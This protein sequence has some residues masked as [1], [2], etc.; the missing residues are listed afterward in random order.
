[1]EQISTCKLMKRLLICVLIFA[2]FLAPAI[3]AATE[4]P[5]TS[6]ADSDSSGQYVIIGLAVAAAV[7]IGYQIFKKNGKKKGDN[8][9]KQENEESSDRAGVLMN[10]KKELSFTTI[11]DDYQPPIPLRLYFN[12][13]DLQAGKESDSRLSLVSG[14]E[15]QLGLTF[16]F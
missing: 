12:I 1:M 11:S 14:R 3:N 5:P 10:Q 8:D 4:K 13:K 7:F 15:I 9:D 16:R 6:E 2:L